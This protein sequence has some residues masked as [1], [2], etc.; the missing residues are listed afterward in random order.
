MFV[1]IPG[2]PLRHPNEWVEATRRL[3]VA[4]AQVREDPLIDVELV[5][6]L[7]RPARVLMIASGGETATLLSSLPCEELHLVDANASQLA[8]CRLKFQLL[9]TTSGGAER[10]RLL[11]HE[12]MDAIERGREIECRLAECECPADALGPV[13]LVAQF[14]PDFCGRY[15]WVF[16]R[17]RDHLADVTDSIDRVM[18][19]SDCAEQSRLVAPN[20]ELG[21]R[22]EAAFQEV[23]EQ[24]RLVSIFGEGATANRLQSFVDHFLQQTR[25]ALASF[26]AVENPFLHQIFLGRFIGPR[27]S[28]IDLPK[29]TMSP[30][31]RYSC[32]PMETVLRDQPG[33]WYD[34]I[35]LSNI[36]DWVTPTDAEQVL[37]NAYRSLRPGGVV[38]V[39]QLNSRLAIQDISCGLRWSR[40][41]GDELLKADR[42][43]FY[44]A[45]HVGV[46]E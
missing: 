4:F 8:L 32:A 35:H 2:E 28:W 13:E 31:T 40:T 11:G 18:S 29:Q 43:F 42:S 12:P 23:M 38:V 27:W 16:A 41:S 10:T 6:R 37:R 22:L 9:E 46:H 44:R 14:G 24:S 21:K 17:M 34:F 19:L 45:L 33:E 20:T 1:W 3:P 25:W 26:P 15:E 30:S 7:E 39:R 36:L 5:R